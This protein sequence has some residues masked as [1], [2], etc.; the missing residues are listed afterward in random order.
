MCVEKFPGTAESTSRQEPPMQAAANNEKDGKH[1]ACA[2]NV[3]HH[4][5]YVDI[6]SARQVLLSS[7]LFKWDDRG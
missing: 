6:T 5:T 3:R 7:S 1:S 2:C 4:A